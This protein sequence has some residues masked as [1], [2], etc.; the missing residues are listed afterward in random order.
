MRTR[1]TLSTW[2]TT[3][4]LLIIRN[5]ENFAE[6]TTL[7]FTYAKL[8][9]FLVSMFIVFMVLSLYLS[10]TILAQWFDPRHAQLEFNKRLI[11]LNLVVDSLAEEVDRKD[12]FIANIESIVSGEDI[13]QAEV[14]DNVEV[15][16]NLAGNENTANTGDL[17]PIDDEIRREFEESG[18]DLLTLNSDEGELQEIFFFPPISGIIS[19]AYDAQSSHLGVDIVSKKNEPVKAVA[20]G[21][22][23]FS[24]FDFSDSGYVIAIQHRGNLISIY[25]HNSALLKKVGNFVS[26][27]EIIAIIG[28]TGELTSGPHLHFELWYDGDHMN[29]EDYISF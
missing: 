9:V 11:N 7:S 23:I 1:K 26:A 16:A 19:Q 3:R 4:Y 22:V 20:D 2:L 24:D 8:L 6:K 10:K 21:T 29:P 12:Q 17:P 5:E 27:G 15:T 14:D 28:N 18:L 25:K 13:N